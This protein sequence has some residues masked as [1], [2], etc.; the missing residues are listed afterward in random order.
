M[1]LSE[2]QEIMN[3]FSMTPQNP[4][5][6]FLADFSSI[7]N[8]IPV[9]S[10]VVRNYQT[11]FPIQELAPNSSYISN[12]STSDENDDRISI[13]E[14]RRQRRMISNRESARRSRMRK[15]RHLDE[16]RWQVVRLRNENHNLIDKLNNLSE[17]HE[18]VVR[19]NECFK[20]E[21]SDLREMAG[22]DDASSD[23]DN[24]DLN[25]DDINLEDVEV[26]NTGYKFSANIVRRRHA[27]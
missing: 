12:N 2:S 15:Q 6:I 20:E 21:T 24:E 13:V 17:S 1:A 23:D 7:N 22:D 26:Q 8:N 4:S 9:T 3:Y 10:Q 14:E 25:I 19:E 18:R 5:N 16:L 11:S 27:Q